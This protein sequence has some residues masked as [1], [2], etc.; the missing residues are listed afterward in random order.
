MFGNTV[1]ERD[2]EKQKAGRNSPR[3]SKPGPARKSWIRYSEDCCESL[4]IGL[5]E[6]R[7]ARSGF[8]SHVA[9]SEDCFIVVAT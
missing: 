4:A 9:H 7:E 5:K 3:F 8:E 2:W 6:I 1:Q